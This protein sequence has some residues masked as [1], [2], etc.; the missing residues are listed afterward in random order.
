M[1]MFWRAKMRLNYQHCEMQTSVEVNFKAWLK[2]KCYEILLF[3]R[4]Q[5]RRVR[6]QCRLK[7]IALYAVVTAFWCVFAA[8][9]Y[10]CGVRRNPNY[11]LWDVLWDLRVS[12]FSSAILTFLLTVTNR[13]LSHSKKLAV[14]Y[15]TYMDAMR[16]FDLLI[17]PYIPCNFA[18]YVPFYSAKT[19]KC[20][21]NW[22]TEDRYNTINSKEIKHNVMQI[23][24]RLNRIEEL[25]D[26]E[27]ILYLK[28]RD[29]LRL[30]RMLQESERELNRLEELN[31]CGF[32]DLLKM[33]FEIIELLRVPWRCDIFIDI[34][35][36]DM[37]NSSKTQPENL[38]SNYY[39]QLLKNGYDFL[40]EE[41]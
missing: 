29:R 15:R 25:I 24:D 10:W 31:Y 21:L 37:V 41:N 9:S 26:E 30:K 14:Q 12:Y 16:D 23:E 11:T 5:W 28:K 20:L 4:R 38:K 27:N 39:Y 18:E 34:K 2:I 22:L 7:D 32:C 13:V 3:G 1:L 19:F 17:E 35:I 33:L 36:M 6:E 40:K 8:F